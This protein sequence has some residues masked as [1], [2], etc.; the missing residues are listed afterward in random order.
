MDIN[1][2][3]KDCENSLR[4]FIAYTLEKEYGEG[5]INKLEVSPDRIAEWEQRKLNDNERHHSTTSDEHLINY[6]DLNDIKHIMLVNWE[7]D[8]VDAFGDYKLI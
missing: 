1:Q 3:L 2:T 6:A 4:D 5:W 7:G 8:F